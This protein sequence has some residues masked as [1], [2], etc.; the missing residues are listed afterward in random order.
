MSTPSP[1]ASWK[2][3]IELENIR[4]PVQ[5]VPASVESK[6]SPFTQVH[7]VDDGRVESKLRCKAC[8]TDV[9]AAECVSA[10]EI[11][12][13]PGGFVH[14]TADELAA[15]AVASREVVTLDQVGYR[16]SVWDAKIEKAYYVVPDPDSDGAAYSLLLAGMMRAA[17]V[18][19][20]KISFRTKE[21]IAVVCPGIAGATLMLFT[22]RMD[23]EMRDCPDFR[24]PQADNSHVDLV[25]K[26][27]ST[28]HRK[29]VRAGRTLADYQD[30]YTGGLQAIVASKR[31]VKASTLSTL[32]QD[33]KTSA[34]TVRRRK[35][36]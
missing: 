36:A 4:V 10:I 34:A 16:S 31:D 15:L 32:V 18:G 8:A 26:L 21:R 20:G 35:V 25:A 14:V 9:T 5:L 7:A 3:I 33:V 13:G 29:T 2:G 19:F 24:L 27:L 17:L 12:K 1:R 23:A 28:V 11:G 22:L 6:D 30:D